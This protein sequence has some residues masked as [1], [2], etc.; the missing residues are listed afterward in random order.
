VN[1]FPVQIS[2]YVLLKEK[3]LDPNALNALTNIIQEEGVVL[4]F[5]YQENIWFNSKRL[6][7]SHKLNTSHHQTVIETIQAACQRSSPISAIPQVLQQL[8]QSLEFVTHQLK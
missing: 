5:G 4:I 8:L 7:G 1:H 6:L 3:E 2:N